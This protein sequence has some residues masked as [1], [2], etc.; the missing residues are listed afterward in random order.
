MQILLLA[1]HQYT[2]DV[3]AID[4][5]LI[6]LVLVML[7]IQSYDFLIWNKRTTSSAGLHRISKSN[8]NENTRRVLKA[9]KETGFVN[10]M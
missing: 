10:L 2:V 6:S 9:E 5:K 3:V 1:E 7:S 4:T 8:G